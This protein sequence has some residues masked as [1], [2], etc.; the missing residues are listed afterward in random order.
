ME[1]RRFPA[2]ISV[3]T[4]FTLIEVLVVIAIIG[5]LIALLLPAVQYARESAR[6]AQCANNLHQL[7]TAV[8]SF[9]TANGTMPPYFGIYPPEGSQ[10]NYNA[11]SSRVF[12]SWFAH[13]T[14]YIDS[15]G[16]WSVMSEDCINANNNY[17]AG[18]TTV[19][20]NG[21]YTPAVPPTMTGGSLQLVT[22]TDANGHQI[23]VWQMVGQTPV[24]GTGS[25]AVG[26]PP[27]VSTSYTANGIFNPNVQSRTFGMLRCMSDPSLGS[28]PNTNSDGHVY[29]QS[30]PITAGAGHPW[31]ATNY[32]ANWW[33]FGG[34]GSSGSG[35][36]GTTGN[37][38]AP[39][40]TFNAIVDGTANT[41]MFAEGYGWCESTGRIALY[42]A[43][44]HNFGITGG[45]GAGSIIV[46]DGQQY[47][48]PNSGYLGNW[49]LPQIG[50]LAVTHANCPTGGNCCDSFRAQTPHSNMNV[51]M[52]DASVKALN[53]KVDQGVWKALMLHNDGG[54]TTG[55][56]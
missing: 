39:P 22:T 40:Q 3:R 45:L 37:I 28:D 25:P 36:A 5:V 54:D 9:H 16:L 11:N 32:L 53:P 17:V 18:T 24:P 35:S 15:S 23:Q 29:T 27:T 6:R 19:T 20:P 43:N 13:L 12:G 7:A 42:S 47:T 30:D 49:F 2:R 14:M 4:G 51:S 31:G 21:P 41:I 1:T 26:T 44:Y 10:Q 52:V 50:P 33:A 55:A 38:F 48:V 34:A 56:Y 46:A 8:H